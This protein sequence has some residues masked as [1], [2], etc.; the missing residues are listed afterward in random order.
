MKGVVLV[1]LGLLALSLAKVPLYV[2]DS[3]TA[4]DGEFIFV[5]HRNVTDEIKTTHMKSLLKTMSADESLLYQYSIGTFHGFGARV[6][7]ATLNAQRQHDD[8]LRYIESNQE[9]HASAC[10]SQDASNIWGLDRIDQTSVTLNNKY[11]HST[12]AGSGV[13]AYIV[14]TGILINHVDFAGRAKWGANF[15]DSQNTDCNGHGTHVAGTVGGKTYGVAKQV[16]L[17]AVKVLTCA[18]SGTNNGVIAGIDWVAAQAYASKKPSVANMSLGGSKSTAINEAVAEAITMGVTFVVAAGNENQDA[19]NTSP[20]PLPLPSLLEPQ[21][22]TPSATSKPMP[23]L[24]SPTGASAF[25]SW[26]LEK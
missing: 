10:T 24:T 13:D 15:A 17:I 11:T 12:T 18:G 19:C 14:D 26:L 6:S 2:A 16:T 5:F 21:P 4:I 1:L 7:L 8:V 20:P 3:L 25:T 23:E 22:S 9:V